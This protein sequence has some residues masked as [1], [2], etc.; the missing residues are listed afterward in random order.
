MG[1]FLVRRV[2][3]IGAIFGL[4][5]AVH[6]ASSERFVLLFEVQVA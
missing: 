1:Q 2:V 3:Q 6:V 4:L 5:A